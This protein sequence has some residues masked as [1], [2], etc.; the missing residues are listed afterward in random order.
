MIKKISLGLSGIFALFFL[1]EVGSQQVK[2]YEY[3]QRIKAMLVSPED[4][5][6]EA[7]IRIQ[8]GDKDADKIKAARLGRINRGPATR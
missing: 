2:N 7:E 8:Y 1:W 3:R 4:T 5:T 6:L